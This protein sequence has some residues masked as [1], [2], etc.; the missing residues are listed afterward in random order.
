[1]KREGCSLGEKGTIELSGEYC[2]A[3]S[4]VGGRKGK[5]LSLPMCQPPFAPF[6]VDFAVGVTGVDG[7][8]PRPVGDRR[9]WR[10]GHYSDR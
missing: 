1:M 4:T 6:I 5:G 2:K 7:G 10:R 9:G 3:S 8:S